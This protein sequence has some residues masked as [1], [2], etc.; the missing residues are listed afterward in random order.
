MTAIELA[1]DERHALLVAAE[2]AVR[3]R[4]EHR[5]PTRRPVPPA[6]MEPGATFVTLR[7]PDDERLL[8]CVGS[9]VA[10][11]PLVDDVAA[12]AVGSAFADPRLPTLTPAEFEVMEIKISVLGALE[13]MAVDSFAALLEAVRPGVDGLLIEA[14]SHR[15]TFL[16]SVW[17][18]VPDDPQRFLALLWQKAGLRP[19]TWPRKMTV[20]RYPTVEFG[21][22][23]PRSPIAQS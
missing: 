7:M 21:T 10:T 13:P 19:G 14:G 16:P 6:V 1:P 17:E 23:S 2:E 5:D 4:L 11:R 20:R 12:N 15:A 8:G 3:A 22:R 9:M 18:Q